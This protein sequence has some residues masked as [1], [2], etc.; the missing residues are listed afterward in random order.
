MIS[1]WY[2]P[3]LHTR[4]E[5]F[6]V[7][8]QNRV[9]MMFLG[10]A[11]MNTRQ[12]MTYCLRNDLTGFD[13]IFALIWIATT[14]IITVSLSTKDNSYL[15]LFLPV[16]QVELLLLILIN[17]FVFITGY[18]KVNRFYQCDV[19]SFI[20]H[21]TYLEVYPRKHGYAFSLCVIQIAFLF[22]NKIIST[23][24]CLYCYFLNTNT[25]FLSLIN[26]YYSIIQICSG[27]TQYLILI[28]RV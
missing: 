4:L 22:L 18:S 5:S 3:F 10:K 8:W 11:R 28:S 27:N 14:K 26:N 12:F 15:P 21:S 19:V 24:P 9:A 6:L 20:Y 1:I 7:E 16:F 23:P 2:N 17:H 13:T 25:V